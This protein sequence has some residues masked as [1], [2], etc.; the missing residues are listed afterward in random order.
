LS[1][2]PLTGKSVF[3]SRAREE[4]PELCRVLESQ[5]AAVVGE[6]LLPVSPPEESTLIDAALTRPR[7]LA[8]W[9][10]TK[11]H[12]VEFVAF[13]SRALGRTLKELSGHVQIGAVGSATSNAAHRAGLQVSY[14]A[15]QQSGAGLAVELAPRVA[16]KRVLLLRS[17]LADSTLPQ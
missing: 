15:H 7:G 13:R 16:G 6:P 17:S 3:V 4:S 5:G 2:R 1:G 10:I 12:A 9:V 8:K 11:R 14:A